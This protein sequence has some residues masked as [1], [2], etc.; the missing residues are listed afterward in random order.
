MSSDGVSTVTIPGVVVAEV[1]HDG[2]APNEAV[3]PVT[4]ET[5]P[6]ASPGAA[7]GEDAQIEAPVAAEAPAAAGATVEVDEVVPATDE[8][9][10]NRRGAS[11]ASG[12]APVN[13]PTTASK[14]AGWPNVFTD[15]EMYVPEEFDVSDLAEVNRELNRARARL[16]RVSQQLKRMQRA[17]AEAQ[18]SYDREMRRQLVSLTGGTEAS[19]RAMAEIACEQFEDRLIIGKQIV[20]EWR[21]RSMDC[22]DDLKAVEN[23][24]HNVRAQIDIR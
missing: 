22:R 24:A 20:E 1:S 4:S 10:T 17:L 2:A 3:A 21:K 9:K 12:G 16:F 8:K 23:I 7:V 13:A 6:P 15:D 14:F 19:R 11:M 5:T 18:V